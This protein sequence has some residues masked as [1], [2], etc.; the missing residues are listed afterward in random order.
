MTGAPCG[1]GTAYPSGAPEFIP[2]FNEV[3]VAQSFVFCSVLSIIVF[4]TFERTPGT[5]NVFY[6]FGRTPGT[7]NVFYTFG[8]TPGT[9]NYH[10]FSFYLLNTW[11]V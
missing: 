8:R 4:Y 1:A 9:Y 5:Y 10:I 7:Y 3:C 2:V 6:T 11:W